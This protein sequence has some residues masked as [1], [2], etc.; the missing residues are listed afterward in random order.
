MVTMVQ[1]YK[2]T[3]NIWVTIG[4]SLNDN[5]ILFLYIILL[6]NPILLY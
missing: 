3:H 1:F 4:A 5:F 2:E 6:Y